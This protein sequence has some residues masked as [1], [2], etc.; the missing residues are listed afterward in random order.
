LHCICGQRPWPSQTPTLLAWV[1]AHQPETYARAGTLCFSKDIIGWHLT[2]QRASD[3][4]DMSGAGLLRLPEASYD[5]GL[6]SLYGLSDALPL[7]PRLCRP[8]EVVGHVASTAASVTGLC[9][10]IPV[11]AGYFDVVASALGS[12]AIGPGTAS[13][14]LGS[15]SINQI[16]ADTPARDPKVFMVAAFG[17]GRFANMD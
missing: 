3:V 7:L 2:G 12:G 6:L 14:V 8:T 10:G 9:E 13:I 17:P 16:F 5:A 4:S 15:W 11:V 1:K